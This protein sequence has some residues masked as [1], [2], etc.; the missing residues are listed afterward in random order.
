MPQKGRLEGHVLFFYFR[1]RYS[2]IECAAIL[3]APIAEITV[4]APV[5]ASPP[6]KTP[7]FVVAPLSVTIIPPLELTESPSVVSLISGFGDVP[8]EITTVSTS[9]RSGRRI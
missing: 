1:E 7:S 6:A 4:A 5:T 8:I 3:P 2:S 9:I